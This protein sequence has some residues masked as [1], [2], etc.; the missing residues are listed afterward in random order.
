MRCIGKSNSCWGRL[1]SK[2]K[3]CRIAVLCVLV[4]MLFSGCGGGIAVK[5]LFSG[6]ETEKSSEIGIA[7]PRLTTL[8]PAVSKQEDVYQISKLIYSG[9]FRLDDEFVPQ[10]DL[11]KS[12]QYD[13]DRETVTITLRDDVKWHDGSEFTADDVKFSIEAYKTLANSGN[14][15]YGSYVANVRSVRTEGKHEVKITFG[16]DDACGMENFTFPILPKHLFS[17]VRSVQNAE[18]DFEPIGT[19]LYRVE[20]YNELSHLTLVPNDSYYGKRAESTLVFRIL[21]E[22]SDGVN[23]TKASEIALIFQD[24]Y[25][26]D[27]L[28]ANRDLR[29]VSY[30]SNKTEVLVFQ[31]GDGVLAKKEIRQAVACLVDSSKILEDVFYNNGILTDTILPGGFYG[32]ENDGDQYPKDEDRAKTLLAAGGLLDR[33]G[34]GYLEDK[35]GQEAVLKFLVNADDPLKEA[36]AARIKKSVESSGIV[37]NLDSVDTASYEAKL[38]AG[39]FDLAI[40]ACT[41]NERCDLRSLLHS[42]YKNPASYKN[43]TADRLVTKLVSG[44]S[45]RE[46]SEAALQLKELLEEDLPYYP[47]FC[48]TY[49]VICA[50]EFTED[51]VPVFYEIYKGCG[52]WVLEKKIK[53]NS[54]LDF[55]TN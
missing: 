19:G 55:T 15:I 6:E 35:K 50:P 51:P 10:P 3:V 33:D 31:C 14:T 42:E 1:M 45:A 8:N 40:A 11:A 34:N 38:A 30:P 27:T 32:I 41:V 12:Y 43:E 2:G 23:L 26:R 20:E 9:L 52:S 4:S 39:D 7:V 21:P 24:N 29:E 5:E 49:G 36:A 48:K 25:D 47:L 22:K 46:K 53:N 54:N 13:A 17:G 16:K 44:D 28:L 18:S 37:V